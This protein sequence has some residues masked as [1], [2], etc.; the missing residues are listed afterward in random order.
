MRLNKTE[1]EVLRKWVKFVIP[2]M[3]KLENFNQKVSD[4]ELLLISYIFYNIPGQS[5]TKRK[6]TYRPPRY[7]PTR[8]S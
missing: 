3:S 5:R 1:R 8:T 4:E 2:Q 6:C 7:L